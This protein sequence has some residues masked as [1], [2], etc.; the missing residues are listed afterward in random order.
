[1]TT[2]AGDWQSHQ[3]GH[4]DY[5]NDYRR[6]NGHDRDDHRYDG[7]HDYRDYDRYRYSYW[8]HRGRGW[9]YEPYWY[10]SYRQT[11]FRYYGG[12]Y[13]GRAR[14]QI[15]FYSMPFGFVYRNWRV[16]EYLSIAYYNS[17][18]YELDDYWSYDLYDPPYWA[19]WVRVGNDALLIDFL[20][21]AVSQVLPHS[22]QQRGGIFKRRCHGVL[23]LSSTS[24]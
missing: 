16:G 19:H 24:R 3:D 1:M 11:H 14:F 21:V 15:S 23:P 4:R 6:G 8:D 10:Q 17:A 7:R 9:R 12:L 2:N 18:R 20:P 5:N 22:A 13:Y